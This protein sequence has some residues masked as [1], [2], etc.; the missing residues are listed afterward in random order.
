MFTIDA[1]ITTHLK[2][3]F[4]ERDKIVVAFSGGVDSLALLIALK[5]IFPDNQITSVY[6]NHNL[7]DEKTLKEEIGTNKRNCE[8]LETPLMVIELA[9]GEVEKTS[10]LRKKGIE[11]AARFLRYQK[12][13]ELRKEINYDYIVTAHTSDD[14]LESS[15]IKLF[16]GSLPK[17]ILEKKG[18]VIRPLLNF[19]KEDLVKIVKQNNFN[20]AVDKTNYEDIYLRNKVRNNLVEQIKSIFPNYKKALENVVTESSRLNE[21]VEYYS[22]LLFEKAVKEKDRVSIELK[23]LENIKEGILVSFYYKVFNHLHQDQRIK[24]EAIEQL[25]KSQSDNWSQKLFVIQKTLVEV[26]EKNLIF[27]YNENLSSSYC[28]LVDKTYTLIGEN[29]VLVRG[30]YLKQTGPIEKVISID[31]SCL[32]GPLLVRSVEANDKIK[33]KE[34][35]KR[36]VKLLGDWKIEA[37]LRHQV[38]ILVDKEKV[39]AVLASSFGGSDRLAQSCLSD[40]LVRN[41]STLYSVVD[42][43]GIDCE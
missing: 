11:E 40:T 21:I 42:M 28:A 34:G 38:P 26:S 20:H 25:I 27:S 6:I 41:E 24:K 13:E 2:T 32:K 4:T 29:K 17:P 5:V 22:S 43:E 16:Q 7:R 18:R 15:L 36:V 31:P 3:L 23:E 14:Q 8:K 39:V 35:T 30:K 33:L 9:K 1:K 19:S 12:L 10:K 37:S